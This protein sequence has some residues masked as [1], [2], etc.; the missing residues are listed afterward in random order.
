M[1]SHLNARLRR[2]EAQAHEGPHR[3]GIA[4]LLE[5]GRRNDLEKERLHLAALSDAELDAQITALAG[6]RGLSLLLRQA[7]E[8]ERTRRQGAQGQ[9]PP[10]CA[11][12]SPTGGPGEHNR[13]KPA[14]PPGGSD[15]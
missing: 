1:L 11:E 15:R 6:A 5:W 10:A 8:E 9:E 4:A 13:P 7:L 12:P 2:L 14:M 3:Q